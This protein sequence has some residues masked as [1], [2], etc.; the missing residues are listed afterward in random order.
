MNN[1]PQ[2]GTNSLNKN[3]CL[4]ITILFS[5]TVCLWNY[6]IFWPK[7]L[8]PFL[9]TSAPKVVVGFN[10]L[11]LGLLAWAF[12]LCFWSSVVFAQFSSVQ[13]AAL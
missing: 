6:G 8:A 13:L 7:L 2:A 12:L 5:T 1:E 3:Y 10:F 11:C 9:P 4:S